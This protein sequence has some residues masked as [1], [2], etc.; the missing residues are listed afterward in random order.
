MSILLQ[1]QYL[2]IVL[3]KEYFAV[4]THD[5]DKIIKMQPISDVPER[6]SVVKGVIYLRDKVI[7]LISMRSLF[8]M[9]E[10]AYTQATRI[11]IHKHQ[12]ESVGLIVD[13]VNKVSALENIKPAMDKV[14]SVKGCYFKG[15]TVREGSLVGIL[16]MNK[17][18]QV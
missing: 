10:E 2:E 3:G 17:I 8:G 11:I 1:E 18:I 4:N 16:N 6:I 15:V 9:P 7:P 12:R 5:V 13:Q 14:G